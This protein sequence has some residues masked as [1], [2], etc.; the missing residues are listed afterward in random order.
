MR[1]RRRAPSTGAQLTQRRNQTLP[2]SL[3]GALCGAPYPGLLSASGA[4]GPSP[5]A[6]SSAPVGEGWDVGG[7]GNHHCLVWYRVPMS[8]WAATWPTRRDNLPPPS[9][10]LRSCRIRASPHARPCTEPRHWASSRDS[11]TTSMRWPRSTPRLPLAS[12]WP[13]C[14]PSSADNAGGAC[15]PTRRAR[16]I[17]ICCSTAAIA[18]TAAGSCCRIRACTC[19]HSSCAR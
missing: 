9:R 1:M 5:G 18:A 14:K 16:S 6:P 13:P 15:S 12:Y 10:R 3:G 4:R 7:E 2:A 19:G 11:R 17:S 8:G